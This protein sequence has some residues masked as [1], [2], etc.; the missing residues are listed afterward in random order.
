MSVPRLID[1][2]VIASGCCATLA[3]AAIT[4]ELTT[5]PGIEAV[6]I[7]QTIGRVIVFYD[8][9]RVGLDTI[10]YTLEAVDYPAASMPVEQTVMV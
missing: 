2:P 7:E 1:D 10:R 5:W 8:P 4:Q 6:M 9:A 3:E